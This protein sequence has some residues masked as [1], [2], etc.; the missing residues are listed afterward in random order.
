[1]KLKIGNK[2]QM[3]LVICKQSYTT[4]LAI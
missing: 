2:I 4:A 1:M 3:Y